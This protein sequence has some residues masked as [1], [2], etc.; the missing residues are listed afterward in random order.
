LLSNFY[1]NHEWSQEGIYVSYHQ[2]PAWEMP[3][4]CGPFHTIS[5]NVTQQEISLERVLGGRRKV[6]HRVFS[7][8]VTI[9]SAHV[10][11][12]VR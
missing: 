4:F 3:E 5:I 9:I 6:Q 2:Q 10:T 11:D 12:Q 1:E 7:D 8:D